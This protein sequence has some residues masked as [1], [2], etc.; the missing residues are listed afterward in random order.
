MRGRNKKPVVMGDGM[1][2]RSFGM[3]P[4]DAQMIEIRQ[5]AIERV[6]ALYGMPLGMVGLATDVA[7]A[8]QEF[9]TDCLPPYCE[10]FTRML[11][12]R[13]LVGEYDWTQ[14]CFEFNL[15][16]KSVNADERIQ[17]LVSA[18]GRSVMLTNEARA[19]LN[20][21]P[22][23]DGDELVTPLNVIVG[24]K[25]SPMVMPPQDPNKPAQD[26]SYRQDDGPTPIGSGNDGKALTGPDDAAPGMFEPLPQFHP[27]RAADIERQRR[28]IDEFQGVVQH[29]FNR[30][31]RSLRGK[32]AATDWARWD[33]E[34]SDD[35]NQTLRRTVQ[36]EGDLY[37]LKLAS[38]SNFDMG[39]VQHYLQAMAEGVATALNDTVRQEIS[40]MGLDDAMARAPQ[41][42]A[43]AGTS[44]GARSTMW[45][46][47]EAA[48]QSGT[49]DQ[50]IKTWVADSSR[51][52]AFDGDTVAVGAEDW[53]AGFAPGSAPGCACTMTVS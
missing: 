47:E 6:A 36:S 35:L 7:G 51:H 8:R 32:A 3:S 37:M 14:G 11:N 12:Q 34:F 27:R 17:T 4:R 53:P 20:L 22:V 9:L 29:H 5:W 38:T 13:V 44:V 48:R 15:D 19:V 49:F 41:H 28:H 45:T 24:E 26:G 52:A 18:T 16:E 2:A 21:P 40:Q 42:V 33:R 25:P 50:R 31:E 1:E 10:M 30:L 46:R 39:R 43:S 23:D